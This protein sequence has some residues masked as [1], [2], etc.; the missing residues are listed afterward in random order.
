ML[1]SDVIKAFHNTGAQIIEN[2]LIDS[3]LKS[4]NTKMSTN[5]AF[6]NSPES[7]DT[8]VPGTTARQVKGLKVELK[9]R[10]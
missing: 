4:Q 6:K 5:L 10:P 1:F 9:H 7:L 3:P 8:R 2:N